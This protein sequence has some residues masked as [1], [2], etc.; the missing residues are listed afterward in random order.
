MQ[1]WGGL[2]SFVAEISYLAAGRRGMPEV[3]IKFFALRCGE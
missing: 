3:T 1:V 2:N